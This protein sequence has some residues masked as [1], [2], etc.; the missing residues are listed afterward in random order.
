[1]IGALQWEVTLGRFDIHEAIYGFL[2]KHPDGTITLRTGIPDHEAI[3]MP[4]TYAWAYSLYGKQPKE[5]PRNLP[6]PRGLPVTS[7]S[8]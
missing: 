8:S 4:E 6:I 2:R 5:L 3:K 7:S 1:M